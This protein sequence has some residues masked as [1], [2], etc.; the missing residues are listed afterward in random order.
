[1]IPVTPESLRQIQLT[2]LEMLTE[3]HRICEKNKIPYVII[4]GTLLGAV[5]HKGFIPWDDDADVA[6][7]R[8]DYERF[9]TACKRDLD[10]SRFVFQDDRNTR[11]YRWGYGK[12]RRKKTLFLR[13]HQENM[14]YF[15]G[16]FIDV[17]PLDEVPEDRFLRTGW[18]VKC[19]LIRKFLWARVGKNADRSRL[20]RAVYALMD[21]VPEDKIRAAYHRMIRQ[22]ARLERQHGNRPSRN[23]R[24]RILMFPTPNADYAYFRRWYIC[25]RKYI[26]EG[27]EFYGIRKA[28]EYL[29]FKF[30]N[31][32]E[33][34]PEEERKTHPVSDLKLLQGH[35]GK[36]TEEQK[37]D[38]YGTI[39]EKLRN[40]RI[41]I[42]GTGFLASEFRL[43]LS[44]AGAAENVEAY[45]VTRKNGRTE[46]QGKPVL[47]LS[48][49]AGR[50]PDNK[51]PE[52][53]RSE[54]AEKS[55]RKLYLAVHE[56]L[57]PEV[58][59]ELS[60]YGLTGE[61]IGSFLPDLLYGEPLQ[62]NTELPLSQILAK[63][64]RNSYWLAVRYAA[65]E[66]FA[67]NEGPAP[68]GEEIYRKLMALHASPATAG[69]RL[70]F[71]RQ[72][73]EEIRR[74]GFDP[75]RPVLLDENGR[76]ID[77]LHRIVLAKFL[78]CKTLHCRIYRASALYDQV[79]GERNYISEKMLA[80]AG[81]TD[82]ER[83]ALE[84]AQE[85][86]FAQ[87]DHTETVPGKE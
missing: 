48:E 34:P 63:Q 79:L 35:A 47:S 56:S 81:L 6:M 54:R 73:A 76:I 44:E 31:Y 36:K 21:R 17:F 86:L 39:K 62:E 1:M 83:A 50:N 53:H 60:A 77:G 5:R 87:E 74:N 4:A 29:R 11:G 68:A 69:K 30:G 46:F 59:A 84:K 32:R 65:L 40:S 18:N 33:L 8:R 20:K 22:S 2:E 41:F 61:W 82:E 25:R 19:F 10:K 85:E 49:Y 27:R 23:R 80:E 26:F 43:A 51:G 37:T 66:A 64:D 28:D 70:A 3:V 78:G 15:Q 12:L 67:D 71:F 57:L 38:E 42:F 13:E 45:V 14:P 52:A 16:I 58:T 75:G 7:L 55:M 9:R 72:T 24:V